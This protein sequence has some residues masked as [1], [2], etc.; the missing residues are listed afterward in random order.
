MSYLTKSDVGDWHVAGV[1]AGN[2]SPG[3]STVYYVQ[4]YVTPQ[5]GRRFTGDVATRTWADI[6]EAQKA[7]DS[8][9]D[10]RVDFNIRGTYL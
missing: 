8:A 1:R 4:R 6:E 10:G 2:G 5:E 3:A 7:A 9:N